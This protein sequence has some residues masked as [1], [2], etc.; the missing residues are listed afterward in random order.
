MSVLD[1]NISYFPSTS[2]TRKGV[3]VNL[4]TLLQSTRHEAVI[5]ELRAEPDHF[6]QIKIKE[7]LPCYTVAGTF[8]RRCEDGLIL[9]SGLAAVDLD[10]AED[11]DVISL[12]H[13]LDKIPYIAYAGLSCRGKRIF[14]IIP[15]LHPEKY[16]KQYERLIKS[17]EDI[18][19]PMGDT[20]HKSISQP[21]YI[22]HNTAETC[23]YNHN[24][25]PYYLLPPEKTYHYVS[26]PI[27]PSNSNSQGIPENPFKWCE[28]QVQK[29]HS[30]NNGNRHKYIISLARYCNM[31]GITES[32]TLANCLSY[33]LSE[34]FLAEEI[35]KIIKH[36][37]SKHA[38]SHNELPFISSAKRSNKVETSIAFKPKQLPCIPIT[39]AS[40]DQIAVFNNAELNNSIE[41][42]DLAPLES[43]FSSTP[44][45][46]TPIHLDQSTTILNLPKFISG[47][48][49]VLHTYNGNPVFLPYLYRLQKLH[50]LLAPLIE[51]HSNPNE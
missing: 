27:T 9:P 20:C 6:K 29:S 5:N 16:S 3:S 22:S 36:V 13:E 32:D 18:G 19:L 7:R 48:L 11:Y 51:V 41:S 31:K 44:L 28:A 25:K 26:R 8:S 40:I 46:L 37:Y 15:F 50:H 33:Y 39:S 17:F 35:N 30:F 24:A 1:K 42:W 21:R 10:S 45:P 34:D 23:F 43:F 49:A 12:L 4:L 47:H 2:E 38:K 14:A